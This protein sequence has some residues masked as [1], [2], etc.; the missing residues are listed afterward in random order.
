MECRR[1][2]KPGPQDPEEGPLR[3][4][5]PECRPGHDR[6]HEPG[7][8][9]SRRH[10][11]R[12][13]G[14]DDGERPLVRP[15]VLRIGGQA[16]P[17]SRARLGVGQV[18]EEQQRH[19]RREQASAVAAGE[20][21]QDCDGSELG[22]G[23]EGERRA[24]R[25]RRPGSR[26]ATRAGRVG[27]AGA[28]GTGHDIAAGAG[29]RNPAGVRSVRRSTRRT[30]PARGQG[31]QEQ[32]REKENAERLEVPAPRRLDHQQGRPREEDEGCGNGAAGPAGHSPQHHAGRQVHE[33]PQRLQRDDRPARQRARREDRLGERR[34]DGGNGRVVDAR[35]PGGSNRFQLRRVRRVQIGVD[36][37]ELHVPVPEIA[38]DVV[39]EKRSAGE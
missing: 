31:E 21:R 6:Q 22:E 33:R 8:Q 9:A 7:G 25:P 35:V 34:V 30:D 38:V 36:P 1:E 4:E 10:R 18:K 11:P 13:D 24:H 39:G 23:G 32:D 27:R 20:H 29:A 5:V 28:P 12:Q 3:I 14:L 17:E 15:P 37:L 26:R 2:Q 16:R 19:A